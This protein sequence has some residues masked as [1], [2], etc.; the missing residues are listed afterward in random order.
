MR[1]WEK[2]FEG[3]LNGHEENSSEQA[4]EQAPASLESSK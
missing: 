3:P 1:L 2:H 4:I